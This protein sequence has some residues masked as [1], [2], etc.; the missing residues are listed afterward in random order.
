MSMNERKHKKLK[1]EVRN[2]RVVNDRLLDRLYT[3]GH[4]IAA[5][6]SRVDTLERE[7]RDLC[8]RVAYLQRLQVQNRSTAR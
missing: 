1:E 5:L 7:N 4:K 3:Q 6:E 8:Q 2:T